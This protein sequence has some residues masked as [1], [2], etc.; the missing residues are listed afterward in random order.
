MFDIASVN[1]KYSILYLGDKVK[2]K[3]ITLLLIGLDDEYMDLN[4]DSLN[5]S[6]N[7]YKEKLNK[8]ANKKFES[9]FSF[10]NSSHLKFLANIC[11]INLTV[12]DIVKSTNTFSVDGFKKTIYIVKKGNQHGL[13][14]KN[15]RKSN[16]TS[17]PKS[18]LPALEKLS[19][20]GGTFEVTM[21]QSSPLTEPNKRPRNQK[22]SSFSLE[23]KKNKI[24]KVKNERE[25]EA[26]RLAKE[27]A[28][29]LA[30]KKAEEEAEKER[31]RKATLAKKRQLQEDKL[32][33]AA[34]KA[35]APAPNTMN[36][37][38]AAAATPPAP[39]ELISTPAA[40][41][42]AAVAA[43]NTYKTC[44]N[45]CLVNNIVNVNIM[46]QDNKIN[47][48][49]NENINDWEVFLDI[50][51]LGSSS[52]AAKNPKIIIDSMVEGM[53]YFVKRREYIE[54]NKK[55]KKKE[56]DRAINKKRDQPNPRFRDGYY[57]SSKPSSEWIDEMIN[58]L[59]YKGVIESI[60]EK[61]REKNLNIEDPVYKVA[62][63]NDMRK[64]L[65][66]IEL[67]E[68]RT[69]ENKEL[70]AGNL[71]IKEK[72]LLE[73][74][75]K[76]YKKYEA[77]ETYLLKEN[78]NDLIT[79]NSAIK[80]Q[81]EEIN[82]NIKDKLLERNKILKFTDYDVEVKQEV[83]NLSQEVLFGMKMNLFD[84]NYNLAEDEY[85]EEIRLLMIGVI[86]EDITIK[87][88]ENE[89]EN[90]DENDEEDEEEDDEEDEEDDEGEFKRMSMPSRVPFA[91]NGSGINL[92]YGG[93]K[94]KNNPWKPYLDIP[95]NKNNK[96]N[97]EL[98]DKLNKLSLIELL[99]MGI[100]S[101]HDFGE[102]LK[103]DGNIELV[104]K[105]EIFE[106]FIPLKFDESWTFGN[107]YQEFIRSLGYKFF[108]VF[109]ER[110]MEG[111]LKKGES[112]NTT[113]GLAIPFNP[114]ITREVH[115]IQSDT[116]HFKKGWEKNATLY[117]TYGNTEPAPVNYLT[118]TPP[119]PIPPP[120]PPPPLPQPTPLGYT[121]VD[122]K[123]LAIKKNRNII[124]FQDSQGASQSVFSLFTLGNTFMKP[125]SF[126]SSVDNY[127]KDK[128][129][130]QKLI[131]ELKKFKI[132]L[133]KGKEIKDTDLNNAN[134]LKQLKNILYNPF[135]QTNLNDTSNPNNISLVSSEDEFL[136]KS[137][138]N[139]IDGAGSN[140]LNLGIF[141]EQLNKINDKIYT[142]APPIP[143]LRLVDFNTYFDIPP[144]VTSYFGPSATTPDNIFSDSVP[145]LP[146]IIKFETDN[147]LY[148]VQLAVQAVLAEAEALVK[149][150]KN[151]VAVA[152]A[153]E[154]KAAA[155][156]A[157][158]TKAV[159]GAAAK[160]AATAVAG[161]IDTKVSEIKTAATTTAK[162]KKA[163]ATT[164]AKAKKAAAAATA[165]VTAGNKLKEL[166]NL[167]ILPKANEAKKVAKKVA[168]QTIK[169]G[170]EAKKSPYHWDVKWWLPLTDAHIKRLIFNDVS[171]KVNILEE[172]Y[173]GHFDRICENKFTKVYQNSQYRN[174]FNINE[175]FTIKFE[176][177][178]GKAENAEKIDE[179][180]PY[181]MMSF[182]EI[183]PV[184]QT[185]KIDTKGV[186]I[187]HVAQVQ[188]DHLGDKEKLV[189]IIDIINNNPA[190]DI[191]D[192]YEVSVYFKLIKDKIKNLPEKGENITIYLYILDFLVHFR[193]KT[194][195]YFSPGVS[196]NL[197]Y[198]TPQ[199]I[200]S[201]FL[202]ILY[203]FKMMGDQGQV[204]FIKALKEKVT[205]FNQHFEV[206][207][208][209]HDSLCRLYACEHEV[210]NMTM[211]EPN[212]PSDEFCKSTPRGMVYYPS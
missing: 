55:E 122:L 143:P 139:L 204:K 148:D 56:W 8:K 52:E 120:P 133:N 187:I 105:N 156:K 130:R 25:E 138:A 141:M 118:A 203:T 211:T 207:L 182:F 46:N 7:H 50:Y 60:S 59:A 106:D 32:A 152:A 89:E 64:E 34:R 189:K 163:A 186:P 196:K 140:K 159:A 166:I 49:I 102:I 99:E 132:Q 107:D 175:I 96:N 200:C 174:H 16:Y 97:F 29:R 70:L 67:N 155:T 167:I 123:K 190:P 86:I 90:D 147:A 9:N 11:K 142:T 110:I 146:S 149:K 87:E 51:K 4:L 37:S 1:D 197:E 71:N 157:G 178:L 121:G 176:V 98:L 134:S 209:T 172:T 165:A 93:A 27:E 195:Y 113:Q 5:E 41:T 205:N 53:E 153:T 170:N 82:I 111:I 116:K 160:A 39:T 38:S 81:K 68:Q 80:K 88:D 84:R 10:N 127:I 145:P 104:A 35:A 177:V 158:A 85:I 75:I 206:L 13:V 95:K 108:L 36:K 92:K 180:W 101:M 79:W 168:D 15:N 162:A 112:Y 42:I 208:T 119:F 47:E 131:K 48:K 192:T 19:L 12:R 109:N 3:F 62:T 57:P 193:E 91:Q 161:A 40:A 184:T 185:A 2:N 117:Y 28:L 171:E 78:P 100:D 17:L 210:S 135:K 14:L 65:Q 61:R 18:D 144:V 58:K 150:F 137:P 201:I 154:A 128:K 21:V 26:E 54:E 73:S 202:R 188:W 20:E 179:L 43:K 72:E 33:E 83:D 183:D 69:K 77:Y 126:F 164:T 24:A 23:Q 173:S 125:G 212:F 199:D 66:K 124:I 169:I 44:I 63:T 94:K 115:N 103:N 181:L 74:L 30:Q 151:V 76:R 6:S 136:F 191:T 31:E 22:P 129:N 45:D 194:S 114:R 198:Y